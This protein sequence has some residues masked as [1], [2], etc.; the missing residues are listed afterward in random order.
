M[1][2][3]LKL[4]RTDPVDQPRF[5]KY[6]GQTLTITSA[7]DYDDNEAVAQAGDG[8]YFGITQNEVSFQLLEVEE[9]LAIRNQLNSILKL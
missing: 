5:A 8:A 9:A 7:P 6:I 2:V 1:V 4:S 3:L